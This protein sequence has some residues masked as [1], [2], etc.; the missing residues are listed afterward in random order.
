MGGDGISQM[1]SLRLS[2]VP[3]GDAATTIPALAN[4]T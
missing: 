3:D 1:L 4:L 2:D